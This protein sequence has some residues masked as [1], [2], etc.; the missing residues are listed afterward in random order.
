MYLSDLDWDEVPEGVSVLFLP[1]TEQVQFVK[2]IRGGDDGWLY[3]GDGCDIEGEVFSLDEGWGGP[4]TLLERPTKE[5]PLCPVYSCPVHE[6][7]MKLGYVIASDNTVAGLDINL[8]TKEVFICTD[9]GDIK[10]IS[11][12]VKYI[13][14]NYEILKIS[15]NTKR[16]QELEDKRT[17]VLAELSE[18]DQELQR[19]GE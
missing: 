6:W 10:G 1:T 2:N 7:L 17:K 5:Q 3:E 13:N 11:E 16:K 14:T 8:Q 15:E 12:V 18:I 9:F 4:W 19:Y